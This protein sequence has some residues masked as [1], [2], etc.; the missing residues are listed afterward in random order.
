MGYDAIVVGG[1]HNG[2]VAG[3]YLARA[4]LRTLILERRDI[5]GGACVTEEFAPGYRAS[6]GAYVLSML[7]E[8]IWRD[9]RLV[10]RGIQ[11]DAAGPTLNVFPDGAHY[12]LA[13]DM[14]LTLDETRRFSTRDADALVRLE[15]DLAP[16][17]R[18]RGPVLRADGAG[19]ARA[20]RARSTRAGARGTSGAASIGRTCW[21]W[22]S[23][24]P[25]RR[26]SSWGSGSSPST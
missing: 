6:T 5:V 22:R 1:G 11:V 14:N 26:R 25:R 10:R 23:C 9:M 2:L 7:R 20:E 24:S 19:S 12:Y 3:F 13:D 8:S 21:I 16:A 18:C 15:E 17:R 4:G